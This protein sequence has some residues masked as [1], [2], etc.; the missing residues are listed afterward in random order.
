MR[1]SR[2]RTTLIVANLAMLALPTYAVA[3]DG[4]ELAAGI[5]L[6]CCAGMAGAAIASAAD[7]DRPEREV[8]HV[9]EVHHVVDEPSGR[10]L[11]RNEA[12]AELAEAEL[13]S[14]NNCIADRPQP[15]GVKVFVTFR[16]DNGKVHKVWFE[17]ALEGDAF[18]ACMERAFGTARVAPFD[19][20]KT[21][22]SKS[23]GG[24]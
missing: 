8:H 23:L 10:L 22:V 13:W 19:L 7:A 6:G 14:Q 17:P 3:G 5:A 21:T 16:G 12:R 24:G 20:S 1:K 4:G 15:P 2:L 9:T 18:S 11:D